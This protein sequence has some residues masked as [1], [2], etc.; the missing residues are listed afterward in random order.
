MRSFIAIFIVLSSTFPLRLLAGDLKLK[1]DPQKIPSVVNSYDDKL[2]KSGKNPS[3]D[4]PT[5]LIWSEALQQNGHFEE[6]QNLRQAMIKDKNIPT[7]LADDLHIRMGEMALLDGKA[8]EAE[9]EFL[10]VV[11]QDGP[12]FIDAQMNLL[13]VALAKEDQTKIAE[14]ADQISVALGES[15][16]T[17]RAI[18][19]LAL[20]AYAR[21]Q[22]KDSINLLELLDND[23]KA[24]YFL[25]LCHRK[26][27]HPIEALAEW[28]KI[29]QNKP[30]T[31]WAELA[32]FQVAETYFQQG[33]DTL[34]RT[35]CEKALAAN[36]KLSKE[37]I[38]RLASLDMKHGD[39]D[40]A[41]ARL[42]GSNME[43]ELAERANVV[44][45]ESLVKLG[46]AGDMF[47]ALAKKLPKNATPLSVYQSA[48]ANSFD[49]NYDRSLTVSEKG[50]ED[51]YDA[52]IT[53][54]LL[55]LQ[56]IAYENLG[57]EAE[58]MATHQTIADRFPN[59]PSAAQSLEWLLRAYVRLGRSREAV[60]H[61]TALWAAFSPEIKR[62]H[63]EASFWLG[64]AHNQLGRSE[65]AAQAYE[66][67]L[68]LAKFDHPLVP[69]A[70]FQDALA[71]AQLNETPEALARLEEF[72]Q[73]AARLNKPEWI[74][75]AAV[76]RGHIFFNAKNYQNAVVAYRS[77]TDTPKAKY[78]EALA[79]Y[80]M[81]YYTDAAQAWTKMA[82]A[83]PNDPL[84]EKAMFR[85]GR[86]LFETGKY[87]EAVTA[88]S[89]FMQ[90][91]PKSADVK[92]AMLQSAHALY[93]S[94]KFSEAAPLYASYLQK[95]PT[96]EDM[97]TVTPYLTASYIQTGAPLEE[98][99]KNLH[100]LPPTDILAS[101]R[102]EKGAQKFN[103]KQF[104]EASHIFAR[105]LADGPVDPHATDAN[106]YRQESLTWAEQMPEPEKPYLVEKDKI[107]PVNSKKK[108]TVA[109]KQ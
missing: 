97:V 56:S 65:N 92:L 19:P 16:E 33:D 95:Y 57:L 43:G 84:T 101:L 39:Y 71:R 21:G 40:K 41:V 7:P 62:D 18:F 77:S 22:Y 55:L 79:L 25:G 78:Y 23:P 47:N 26:M 107:H 89:T 53:P 14:L 85:T 42:E 67:F 48:W 44:T 90:K 36:P 99:E 29:Q 31:E 102:W 59:T 86:T 98:I 8:E 54:R 5:L 11:D 49:M 46:R 63:P 2:I 68:K 73:T 28:H 50:L 83:Y 34:S 35:A 105:L 27:G 30:Y 4:M 9:K 106:H 69:H 24:Q 12:R 109:S 94:G 66:Q 13:I 74:E 61:G 88:Y 37:F 76:Q 1:L 15:V 75:L 38:F 3:F 80:K 93:N 72:T 52:E 104:L 60:T 103:E 45:A 6:A 51:F 32:Q 81:E 96:T 108:E 20:A 64:E 70:Q 87:A 58:A 82:A 100:G 91:Y 17:S 10:Q